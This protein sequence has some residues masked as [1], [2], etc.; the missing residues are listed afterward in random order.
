MKKEKA[1]EELYEDYWDTVIKDEDTEER[2][3][4]AKSEEG[5]AQ[6]G[7]PHESS[8]L[9]PDYRLHVP[10]RAGELKVRK[11]LGERWPRSAYKKWTHMK[12]HPERDR[13]FSLH[14]G[15]RKDDIRK[16][17]DAGIVKPYGYPGIPM[18]PFYLAQPEKQRYRLITDVPQLNKNLKGKV[19]ARLPR[20][21]HSYRMLLSAPWIVSMDFS[22]FYFQ[23][24]LSAIHGTPYTFRH[25]GKTYRWLVVPMGAAWSCRAAQEVAEAFCARVR[26][27]AGCGAWNL[28]YIDNLYWGCESE[29]E[30]GRI[31]RAVVELAA[32]VN[33]KFTLEHWRRGAV[34][35]V[36]VDLERQ[37]VTV[38]EAYY[39]RHRAVW[40]RGPRDINEMYRWAG[41]LIRAHHVLRGRLTSIGGLLGAVA[42]AARLRATDREEEWT[43]TPEVQAAVEEAQRATME[44][45]LADLKQDDPLG[46]VSLLVYTDAAEWGAGAVCVSEERICTYSTPWAEDEAY[47]EAWS[48]VDREARAATITLQRLAK[49]GSAIRGQILLAV[50]A[51]ALVYAEKKGYSPNA[52]ICE[53]VRTARELQARVFH[54]RSERNVADAP[55]RGK[56]VPTEE[57]V[58]GEVGALRAAFERSQ[59]INKHP[60]SRW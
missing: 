33:A 50:D 12:Y 36:S 54:V 18:W 23:L 8:P 38:L 11:L 47:E 24:S 56:E 16:L 34:L 19:P 20:I 10:E 6:S 51:A 48:Q 22:C 14:S 21:T 27:M 3:A 1:P 40:A 13:Q 60:R 26:Q 30:A 28:T 31:R 25:R 29:E 44:G 35:G 17:L 53:F 7:P 15:P 39:N 2:K 57:S 55:S 4:K 37:E 43:C 42:H 5:S 49:Q 58:L 9:I 59:I 41:V 46:E 52:R 45:T 32:Q